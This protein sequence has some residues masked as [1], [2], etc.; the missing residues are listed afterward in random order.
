MNVRP[1][2]HKTFPV[3]CSLCNSCLLHNNLAQP[4][5][6]W[7]GGLSPWKFSSVYGIPI[8]YSLAKVHSAK[9]LKISKETSFEIIYL[10]RNAHICYYKLVRI[11]CLRFG[12]YGK[13]TEY[14][15]FLYFNVLLL[16]KCIGGTIFLSLLKGV[17]E[18]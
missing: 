1:T 10:L 14:L 12:N 3:G 11:R 18:K 7:I 5:S 15:E 17:N 16:S 13:S 9:V 6:V 8:Q 4:D 2:F